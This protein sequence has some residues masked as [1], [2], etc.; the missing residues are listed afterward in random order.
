MSAYPFSD[1]L[2]MPMF[3]TVVRRRVPDIPHGFIVTALLSI[4]C[5]EAQSSM[6]PERRREAIFVTPRSLTSEGGELLKLTA[7]LTPTKRRY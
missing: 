7:L 4:S 6:K 2:E 1:F 5:A 3:K